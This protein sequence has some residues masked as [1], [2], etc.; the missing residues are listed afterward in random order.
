MADL[1]PAADLGP[2]DQCNPDLEAPE[3]PGCW[4]RQPNSACLSQATLHQ[5]SH[6]QSAQLPRK[7]IRFQ[8]PTTRL[9]SWLSFPRYYEKNKDSKARQARVG[10]PPTQL[11]LMED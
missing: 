8:N 7:H 3:V 2:G 5:Q 11:S 10:P 1:V 4:L 6:A 9:P